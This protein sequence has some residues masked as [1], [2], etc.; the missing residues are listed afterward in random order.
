MDT[1]II[2]AIFVSTLTLWRFPANRIGM[3]LFWLAFIANLCLFRY[4]VT[5]ALPLNF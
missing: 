1:L 5:D 2:L 3:A 4:H